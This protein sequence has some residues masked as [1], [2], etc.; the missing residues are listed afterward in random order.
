MTMKYILLVLFFLTHRSGWAQQELALYEDS[1]PNSIGKL[2]V[3]DQPKL[4]VYFPSNSN[5]TSVLIIPGGAYAFLATSTEGTPIAKAFAAKGI[6]AFVLK[7]RLPKDE[8]MRN[9]SIAPLQ[10]AQQAMLLIRQQASQWKLDVN[11]VGVIGF[12]AGGHLAAML[13]THYDS[14]FISNKAKTNLRPDFMI[15]VYPVISMDNSLT[16]RGSR[17]NLL[18]EN[19][20]M[21]KVMYFSGEQQV[22]RNTPPAYVTHSCDDEVVDVH[23][24]IQFYES[25]LRN[26]IDAELHIYPKGNHGFIQRIPMSEWLD[27]ILL[28]LRKQGFIS[29]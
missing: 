8:S 1:I 28:F 15:L 3:E 5:G 27:P 20:S 25:L 11:K 24:S 7:Y 16:H 13:G 14:S 26:G 2:R 10:D 4:S 21:D 12:S 6:T 9:K 17:V 19:P 29:K 18:G 22:K 23:N